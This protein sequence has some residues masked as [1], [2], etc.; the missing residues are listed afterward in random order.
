M[1][2]SKVLQ[3][4][5]TLSLINFARKHVE[6][7]SGSAVPEVL[8]LADRVTPPVSELELAYQG[9]RPL[10]ALWKAAT[11]DK[12][13]ADDD[14][15]RAIASL[16]YELLGPSILNGD[17]N[18]PRYRSLF[19]EGN[20]GFI[21]GPDRAELVQVGAMV[22]YLKAN[23]EHPMADRA[24]E[25]ES[26]AA[27]LEAALQPMTST[28]AAIRAAWA[29]ER[30]KREALARALR[31]NAALLRAELMDEKKVEALFPNIEESKVEED[32]VQGF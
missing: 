17:R 25:L 3:S 29:Q 11:S 12:D 27:L 24:V 18:D 31:K 28:E 1:N 30:T 20:I 8:A 15:D 26:K 2:I 23:P 32:E 22:A 14:L 7:L 4:F 21:H 16:S 10:M 19:P 9:R 13:A 6:K 5:G